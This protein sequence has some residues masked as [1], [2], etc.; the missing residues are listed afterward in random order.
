VLDDSTLFICAHRL[1]AEALVKEGQ[2]FLMTSKTRNRN[3]RNDIQSNR[4]Q[5]S[6][7]CTRPRDARVQ[8]VPG[9]S[10]EQR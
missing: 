3:R 6:G 8:E 7:R 4:S 1:C 5:Q 2:G 9:V 10:L